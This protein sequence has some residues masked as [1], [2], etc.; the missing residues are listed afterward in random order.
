MRLTRIVLPA[1]IAAVFL[2][3]CGGGGSA[4]GPTEGKGAGTPTKPGTTTPPADPKAADAA[5]KFATDFLQAVRDKQATPDQLTPE[6]AKT[7]SDMLVPELIF[8]AARVDNDEVSVP[9]S[10]D[11][12]V[13]AVGRSKGARSRTL[14]RL[15]KSG[16]DYKVDWLSV[17][18]DGVA[19]ATLSGEDAPAQFAAQ[20]LLDA[21]ILKETRRIPPLLTDNARNTLGVSV[22]TKKFDQGALR[23]KLD[24]L[25]DGAGTYTLTGTSRGSVTADL[26]LAGGKK[27]ATIK[28]VKGTRPGEWLVDAV[29][30]K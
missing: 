28:T 25:F 7:F 9:A 30:V 27:T 8:L 11:G 14:L 22:I 24:E 5:K 29:E 21:A 10:T 13:F 1:L 4:P 26:A 18:P 12:A 20:S 2:S 19:D 3:G 23:S 17:G 16:S 15:V 6:F